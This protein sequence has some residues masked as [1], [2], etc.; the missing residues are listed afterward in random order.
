MRS[1]AGRFSFLVACGVVG[2]LFAADQAKAVTVVPDLPGG[3]PN[4]FAGAETNNSRQ[5]GGNFT[6]NLMTDGDLDTVWNGGTSGGGYTENV[7]VLAAPAHTFN[8]VS[9][10]L[11]TFGSSIN[12][13]RIWGQGGFN[14]YSAG[15]TDGFTLPPQQVRIFYDMK[16]DVNNADANSVTRGSFLT[17]ATITSVN[18]AA[19]TFN[20]DGSVSLV[21]AFAPPALSAADNINDQH[22]AYA[23]DLAVA[24]PSTANAVLFEFGDDPVRAADGGYWVNEI[25]AANVPEPASLAFVAA[26][27]LMVS[28][29]RSRHS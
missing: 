29:R 16:T 12:L 11:E 5:N 17:E 25:Q 23:V 8:N 3:A 19:P 7:D 2:F 18:G 6:P 13:I 26:A 15:A 20:A 22:T 4:L 14:G 1:K 24:I 28:R 10:T 9:D 21:G 27:G